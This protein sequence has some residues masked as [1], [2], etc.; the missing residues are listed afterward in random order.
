M[1]LLIAILSG[2]PYPPPGVKD[3]PRRRRLWA[4]ITAAVDDLARQG[5]IPDVPPD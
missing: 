4:E 3:T 1:A 2:R 5:L